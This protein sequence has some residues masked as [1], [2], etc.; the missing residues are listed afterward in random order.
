MALRTFLF[1]CVKL[2]DYEGRKVTKADI[3]KK[4]LIWRLMSSCFLTIHQSNQCF[5]VEYSNDVDDIY[6]NIE[7]QNPNKKLKISI[8]F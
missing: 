5:L 4:L 2:G 7:E 8:V 1:F 6:K 3:W